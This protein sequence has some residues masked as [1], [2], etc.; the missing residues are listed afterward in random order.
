[1]VG[2]QPLNKTH[3]KSGSPFESNRIHVVLLNK[4]PKIITKVTVIIPI[5]KAIL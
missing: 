1:M 4:I 3:R 5:T 2:T